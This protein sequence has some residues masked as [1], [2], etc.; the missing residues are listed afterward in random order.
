MEVSW[1]WF[2]GV[3]GGVVVTL[4]ALRVGEWFRARRPR[5]IVHVWNRGRRVRRN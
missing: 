3:V 4:L 1:A 5:Y 2:V